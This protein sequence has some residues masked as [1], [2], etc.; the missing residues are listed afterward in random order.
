MSQGFKSKFDQMRENKAAKPPSDANTGMDHYPDEGHG[1]NLCFC[2]ADGKRLFLNYA[3]VVSG[4]FLP[5][6]ETI[7]LHFTTHEAT[8]QG[9]N[10]E[11]LF[12]DIMQQKIKLINC[13][14]KRYEAVENKD[15]PLVYTITIKKL[16]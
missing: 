15:E 8:M 1:R 11:G 12:F 6:N 13:V 5:E 9:A 3:Y 16:E 2:W 10:L 4:E 14:D 7:K